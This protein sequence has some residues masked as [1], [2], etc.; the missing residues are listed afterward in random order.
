MLL[1]GLVTLV[2]FDLSNEFDDFL[3]G[4][5]LDVVRVYLL[6]FEFLSPVDGVVDVDD[7]VNLT[8][9]EHSSF[10]RQFAWKA[11]PQWK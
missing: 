6:S 5:K 4:H 3:K 2:H 9:D 10:S 11:C 8:Q 7:L 1:T